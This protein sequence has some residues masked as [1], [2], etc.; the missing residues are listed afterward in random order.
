MLRGRGLRRALRALNERETTPGE[1][2]FSSLFSSSSAASSGF[3]TSARTEA[4]T[5]SSSSSSDVE[6]GEKGSSSTSSDKTATTKASVKASTAMETKSRTSATTKDEKKE[7]D[8]DMFM[9]NPVLIKREQTDENTIESAIKW[10]KENAKSRF[11]ETVEL[12]IRLGVN[13]KRSDM[14]VRGVVQLPHGTGKKFFVLAFGED[15]NELMKAQRAGADRVGGEALIEEIKQGKFNLNQVDVCIATPGIMA[16]LKAVARTLGPKGLMP[17]PKVGTLTTDLE[18]AVKEAKAG[19]RVEYR[20]EKNSIVH[21]GIGK[22]TFEEG[23]IVENATSLMASVL[24]NRP[25]GKG[26]PAMTNY[27]K[28]IWLSTTMSKGSSVIDAKGF[29]KLGEEYNLKAIEEEKR[30]AASATA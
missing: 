30:K 21:A 11:P 19:G 16:K 6:E 2:R 4:P 18:S 26:A 23:M 9:R 7:E 17:N 5:K 25:K 8:R 15:E 10:A 12:T 28:K 22:V 24:Q 14:I 20:A 1:R 13:P 29:I 27:V 3:S